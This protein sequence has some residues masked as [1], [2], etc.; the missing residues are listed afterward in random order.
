MQVPKWLQH[1][2]RPGCYTR[3][4]VTAPGI[5]ML[6]ESRKCHYI[7]EFMFSEMT[8]EKR[9]SKWIRLRVAAFDSENFPNSARTQSIHWHYHARSAM[10]EHSKQEI[11][12]TRR[13]RF[14]KICH[15]YLH[16]HSYAFLNNAIMHDMIIAEDMIRRIGTDNNEYAGVI[17]QIL[18][19]TV[20]NKT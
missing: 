13:R 6:S 4:V 7:S 16:A 17:T 18:H 9:M 20:W 15:W 2:R 19:P 3:M 1:P 10:C 12:F 14:S 8:S 5:W 11:A